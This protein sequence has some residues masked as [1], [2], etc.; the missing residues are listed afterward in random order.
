MRIAIDAM[1]GD[2][3]PTEIVAGAVD[4]C[5]GLSDSLTRVFLVGDEKAIRGELAKF[6][7]VSPKIEVRHAA[8]VIGMDESPA[9]AVR[10]KKDSSIS[11]AVDLITSGEA[12][13]VLSAG[14]TGAVVVAAS[15][16]LRLL[17]GVL[18]PAIATVL[19]TS[20]RPLLLIDAGA[21]VDCTSAILLQFGVM[22]SVYS[23]GVMK[24]AR[25]VVGLMSIGSEDSKGTEVTKETFRLLQKSGLN[26]RGNVEGHDLFRGETD[27]VVCDGFVGNIVLK[28]VESTAHAI[29][30]WLKTALM[31]NVF[32]KMAA[33]IL[34]KDLRAM[35]KQ[36]DPEMHGGAQLLGVNGTCIIAHGASSRRAIYNAI[37][38][39]I[40][41]GNNQ[42]NHHI[43][44]EI[45]KLG[46]P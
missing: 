30:A 29:S 43:I 42:V 7:S 9:L 17:D 10:K 41:A 18:R 46:T 25:P 20:G 23:R 22:G 35:K 21:T 40:D 24:Q 19:P 31:K 26:F 4:A 45:A 2:F 44:E 39:S 13:A 34:Q 11:R 16:K 8:D 38:V 14:N 1:G 3:A 28:T 15:L 27:V 5:T 12:D 37:R 6:P 33:L 36:M 32:N